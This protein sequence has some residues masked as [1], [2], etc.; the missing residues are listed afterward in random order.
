MATKATPK[1]GITL[2]S[3]EDDRLKFVHSPTASG[4]VSLKHKLGNKLTLGVGFSVSGGAGGNRAPTPCAYAAIGPLNAPRS[5]QQDTTV[6]KIRSVPG[7]VVSGDLKVRGEAVWQRTGARGRPPLA[8]SARRRRRRAPRHA[9]CGAVPRP[10]A[11]CPRPRARAPAIGCHCRGGR[12]AT[13][14]LRR[15]GS[16][17]PA[18]RPAGR[19]STKCRGHGGC[20]GR[21]WA[22]P[23]ALTPPRAARRAW[24]SS[25]QPSRRSTTT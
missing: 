25:P 12:A 24:G 20:G 15:G 19:R 13:R 3:K 5:R 21:R 2:L 4:D 14:A 11:P 23:C 1:A 22:A 6:R 17:R 7:L 10:A 18:G 9:C 8:S 16:R